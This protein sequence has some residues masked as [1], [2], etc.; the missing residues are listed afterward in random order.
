LGEPWQ[1]VIRQFWQDGYQTVRDAAG[2]AIKVFIG[3]A[4]L[5]VNV[6]Y[7]SVYCLSNADIV[8][9][10]AKFLATTRCARCA[11]GL[12]TSFLFGLATLLP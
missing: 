10:L 3:D 12:C 11:D 1:D 4:F 6:C 2:S 7:S 5:G 9:E 8:L